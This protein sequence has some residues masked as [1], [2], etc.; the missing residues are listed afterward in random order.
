MP[1]SQYFCT[2]RQLGRETKQE[3]RLR[4]SLFV[5]HIPYFSSASLSVH[6]LVYT[7]VSYTHIHTH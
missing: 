5:P 2:S 6:S 7:P 1:K 3:R 4:G